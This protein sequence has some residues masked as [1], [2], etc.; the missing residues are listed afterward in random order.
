L[1]INRN[2]EYVQYG[3]GW[4]APKG[5]RNFDSS[6]TLRFERIPFIGRLYIKN[7]TR[8]PANVEY[9]DI[10][11]GLPVSDGECAGV[12]CSHVLEH[13]ALQDFREA[14]K[15]TYR[16]LKL[17]GTFR[18]V[19]PDLEHAIQEYVKNDA[20]SASIDFMKETSLGMAQRP[21]GIKGLLIELMGN[22]NHLWMWD[23]KSIVA[24]LNNAGFSFVRR[25][26]FG[27]SEDNQFNQVEELSRWAN[28]LG[29]ECKKE[30]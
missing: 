15:N 23:F 19:L 17:G 7:A 21:R 2:N 11:V 8:F 29:V 25:A 12:Y 26:Q 3:C 20:P 14:L 16:I 5:W 18:L 6:P 9:G 13:L 10:V 4:H 28:A 27:D 30:I 24:E 22:S 1:K